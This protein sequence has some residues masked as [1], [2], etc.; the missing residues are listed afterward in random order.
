MKSEVRHVRVFEGI[1]E[2]VVGRLPDP[3]D[4][5]S[6]GIRGGL[7]GQTGDAEERIC[8][9]VFRSEVVPSPVARCI[10]SKSMQGPIVFENQGVV[11]SCGDLSYAGGENLRGG[12]AVGGGAVSSCP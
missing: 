10:P 4:R 6:L 2:G 8:V 3:A 7:F 11:C 1:S 9:G 5:E 12:R